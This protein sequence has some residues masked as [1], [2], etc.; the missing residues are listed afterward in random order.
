MSNVAGVACRSTDPGFMLNGKRMPGT[1]HLAIFVSPAFTYMF[2]FVSWPKHSPKGPAMIVHRAGTR[3]S[4]TG[5]GPT[6]SSTGMVLLLPT[7]LLLLSNCHAPWTLAT[8][9]SAKS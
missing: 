9:T 2:G 7:A 6:H 5:Q 4:V 8:L 1:T 3:P